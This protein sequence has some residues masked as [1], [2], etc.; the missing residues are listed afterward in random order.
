MFSLAKTNKWPTNTQAFVTIVAK[1]IKCYQTNIGS[2]TSG[3][4]LTRSIL[5]LAVEHILRI[6]FP[7]HL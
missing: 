2:D 1:I 4:K 6:G 7:K 3:A 5:N